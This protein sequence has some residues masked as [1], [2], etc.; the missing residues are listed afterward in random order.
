MTGEFPARR[1]R[2]WLFGDNVD[3]DQM[4]PLTAMQLPPAERRPLLFPEHPEFSSGVQPGDIIVAGRNWGCGSSRENAPQ[5]LL[6]LGVAAV[7]AESFARIFF[8][9]SIA[10]GFPAVECPGITTAVSGGD[11]VEVDLAGALVRN[12]T[13]GSDHAARP[14]TDLMVDIVA[15]GGLLAQLAR[16]T[17]T[18][19]ATSSTQVAPPTRST[20]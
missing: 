3:T 7:V 16:R 19:S 12:V 1:G 15:S 9:N 20:R 4:A 8:R 11:E 17:S 5:N 2:A 13:T 14:Y 18:R 10:L 6:D